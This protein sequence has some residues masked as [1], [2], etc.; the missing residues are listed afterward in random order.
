MVGFKS[1]N[2]DTYTISSGFV[3]D[4]ARGFPKTLVFLRIM[5][6]IAKKPL[7]AKP[8]RTAVPEGTAVWEC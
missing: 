1:E 8:L 5:E 4:E 7:G 3:F 2:L 6:A